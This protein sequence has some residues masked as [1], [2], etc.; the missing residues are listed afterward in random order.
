MEK[1][2]RYE[3][4]YI[5]TPDQWFQIRELLT[6]HPAG[7]KTAFPDRIINNIYYDTPDFSTCRD[8]LSGVSQ[9]KKFRLRWY[10]SPDIIKDAIFEIKI[11]N[12]ALGRKESFKVDNPDHLSMIDSLKNF[13]LSGSPHLSPV[14]QNQYLRS[15]FIN[16]EGNFRLTVDR[17]IKYQKAIDWKLSNKSHAYEDD[18]IIIELKFEAADISRQT[19][20]TKYIPF[21]NSKHSKYVTGIFYCY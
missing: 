9:R 2:W 20:I 6:T 21:R 8:N 7:F 19:E 18:R 15:Y 10:G 12:N 14:L 16:M 17:K 3:V 5:A 13:N 1:D 4:K 11:K